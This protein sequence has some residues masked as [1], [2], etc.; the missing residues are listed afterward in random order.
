[1]GVL[2]IGSN[3]AQLQVVEVHPGAPP[4]PTT[5][6]KEPVLLNKEIGADGSVTL[7][8]MERVGAAVTAAV[9]MASAM[10]VDQLYSFVT[11]AVRDATN[12]DEVISHIEGTSGIRP[13][14]LTGEEEARLT[15]LAAHRWYGWSAGRLLVL[16]IGG[17]SM[18]ISLG[19]D[20]DP[21]LA[22]SLPLGAR[23]LTRQ[24]L[25]D[26]PPTREQLALMRRHVRDTVAEV[27]DRLRWEGDPRRVIGTSKTFKQ[28]ARLA[29]AR[30]QRQ[31][32]FVQRSLT[33][34]DVR[35]W[36]ERL[37]R[38]PADRRAGLRGVARSRAVEVLAGA[39]VADVTMTALNID[40]LDLCPWALREGIILRHL[41]GITSSPQL[42]LTPLV[43][44]PADL[45]EAS[46]A[47]TG[48]HSGATG[49]LRPIEQRASR[50]TV[51]AL[52][53]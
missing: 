43:P 51:A 31:G 32:P 49:W 19:R 30:P 8:G 39:I 1:L 10:G 44:S 18:E 3:A 5:S 38:M 22:M 16:D 47:V 42:P 13:Q 34:R 9:R 46:D 4:L 21:D 48:P 7:E 6:V 53:P 40:H 29:G 37:Q 50:R 33:L 24:F 45:H 27:A 14:Y 2:D 20:S 11:S 41:D 35:R 12:R 15:Y 28:L 52:G 36:A 25:F 26:D 17:G 23:L